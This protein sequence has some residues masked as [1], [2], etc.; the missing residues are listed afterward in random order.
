[1]FTVYS[2]LRPMVNPRPTALRQS[3]G[4]ASHL[5][6]RAIFSPHRSGMLTLSGGPGHTMENTMKSMPDSLAKLG[7]TGKFPFNLFA[8]QEPDRFT[9]RLEEL[10]KSVPNTLPEKRFFKH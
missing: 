8:T 2:H 10:H 5:A 1:M 7:Q 9:E 3:P 6:F 4:A